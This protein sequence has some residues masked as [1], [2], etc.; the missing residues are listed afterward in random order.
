[1]LAQMLGERSGIDIVKSC[2]FFLLEPLAERAVCEPVA[3]IESVVLCDDGTA[4]DACTLIVTVER[5]VL[6]GGRNAVIT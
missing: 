3:V 6:I 5:L 1:M 4:M 2:Y